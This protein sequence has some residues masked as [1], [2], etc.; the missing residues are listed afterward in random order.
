MGAAGVAV[1]WGLAVLGGSA[2]AQTNPDFGTDLSGWE[3]EVRGGAQA[4]GRV[5]WDAGE[6]VLEEGHPQ[7]ESTRQALAALDLPQPD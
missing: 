5:Y 4:P 6:A 1:A 7:I 3:V 2:V